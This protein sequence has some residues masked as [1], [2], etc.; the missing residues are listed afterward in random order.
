MKD[1][2]PN[3]FLSLQKAG[4]DCKS[5]Y[6]GP[7]GEKIG[8]TRDILSGFGLDGT[9]WTHPEVLPR[10]EVAREI[11]ETYGLG[12]RITDAWR[13]LEF[14]RHLV[15]VHRKS[16]LGQPE[17]ISQER[18]PHATGM[19]IDVDLIDG[20]TKK[21]IWLRN[22]QV[23][24]HRSAVYGFYRDFREPEFIRYHMLQDLLVSTFL[25]V[26][27][28]LGEKQEYWHFEVDGINSQKRY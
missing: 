23:H 4:H 7:G 2:R 28:T 1:S 17:L 21:Q 12:V 22:Q 18:F 13:P 24:G 8:I 3:H 26:G 9:L 16:P 19:A 15:V 6:H 25:S 27:F 14:C 5:Y 20:V 11:I 10:L